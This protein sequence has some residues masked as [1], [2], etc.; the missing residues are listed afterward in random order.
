MIQ[1][2][3]ILNYPDY[4]PERW[5]LTLIILA[6]LTVE[7]LMNMYT[8][9]LIPWIELLAGILHVVLFIV[10]VVVLVALAPRHTA[11]YVF[12]KDAGGASGWTNNFVSWNIGLVTPTWGFV[13]K[14]ALEQISDSVA[15]KI[16]MS[17][18]FDGAVHMSE[19]VRRAKQAIPR[20]MF[21]TVATNGVLAYTIIITML[22]TMG[23]L[24]KAMNSSFPIIEICLQ[25]TGSAKA[26]TAMVC[27]LLVISL[28]VNLASIASVSRL[29]WAWSRDGALPA[30]FSY[31]SLEIS[32]RVNRNQI[33][34]FSIDRPKT[35][36]SRPSCLAT[37]L[38]RQPSC[39]PQ[40]RQHSCIR[41]LHRPL[42][43]RP[44]YFLPDRYRMHVECP[45]W[46]GTPHIGAVEHGKTRYSSQYL[47]H[48]LHCL[49]HYLVPIPI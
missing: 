33:L 26:A 29:T 6:M 13:G 46:E 20:S 24:D 44:L 42:L 17:T 40:H 36:C 19:E 2:L 11:D 45:F 37:P 9:K 35:Q 14:S 28:S 30:W 16:N 34:I 22:F 39:L 10:F 41:S 12:L 18:G 25:A 47:C 38:R 32:A 4:V 31:V 1:G 27:G 49:C 21:W 15:V 5:H 23:P 43:H 8:F 3:V 7:G 48:H